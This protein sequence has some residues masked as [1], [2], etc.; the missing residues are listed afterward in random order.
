MSPFHR[1]DVLHNGRVVRVER[2]ARRFEDALTLNQERLLLVNALNTIGRAG[3]CLLVDSRAA[4]HSTDQDLEHEFR[5][6]RQE[7]ARGFDRVA[8]LVRT[9][10]GI[11][12]VTR[13]CADQSSAVQP[14]N[15]EAAAIAYLLEAYPPD[16]TR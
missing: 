6:F 2:T 3:R 5:R 10:V 8:A 14:F 4:P 1:V 13:L 16:P 11:L 7:V 15:D 12:Q 9:K